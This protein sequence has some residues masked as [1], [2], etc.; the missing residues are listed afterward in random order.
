MSS[1]YENKFDVI[2]RKLQDEKD[3]LKKDFDSAYSK[4]DFRT[5]MGIMEDIQEVM[6]K[7]SALESVEKPFK[8]MSQIAAR[9]EDLKMEIEIHLE[10]LGKQIKSMDELQELVNGELD[11]PMQTLKELFSKEVDRNF[12]FEFS[13]F[14]NDELMTLIHYRKSNFPS[15]L[16]SYET[17][18]NKF[19]EI[20]SDRAEIAFEKPSAEVPTNIDLDAPLDVGIGLAL[21]SNCYLDTQDEVTNPSHSKVDAAAPSSGLEESVQTTRRDPIAMLSNEETTRILD[22]SVVHPSESNDSNWHSEIV[23]AQD[24]QEYENNI[25]FADEATT[26]NAV[27]SEIFFEEQDSSVSQGIEFETD[28]DNR[29]FNQPDAQLVDFEEDQALE[30]FQYVDEQEADFVETDQVQDYSEAEYADQ[31]DEQAE[32]SDEAYDQT[33]YM[34]EGY[35]ESGYSGE[36]HEQAEYSDEVYDQTEYMDQG[37]AESGYSGEDHEQAEYSEEAY[38]QTVY[39]EDGYEDSEYSSE[40]YEQAEYSDEAYN[41]T[42]YMEDGYEYSEYSGEGYEQAE[43]TEESDQV[44]DFNEEVH[45]ETAYASEDY[46]S[47]DY[48]YDLESQDTYSQ[49]Q[50]ELQFDGFESEVNQENDLQEAYAQADQ[51]IEDNQEIHADVQDDLDLEENLPLDDLSLELEIEEGHAS[52]HEILDIDEVSL[53]DSD[54]TEVLLDPV[55][56][57]AEDDVLDIDDIEIDLD[58]EPDLSVNLDD[59]ILDLDD[60]L[61]PNSNGD[62][63][64]EELNL[65]DIE[66]NLDED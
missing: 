59:E 6:N 31:G 25:S 11:V 23:T 65:D 56:A 64:E 2:F 26:S 22:T 28:H 18:W 63:L 33:E 8:Q 35:E 46:E 66:I 29:T 21:Q 36:G 3:Q 39:M 15:R 49:E 34:D 13:K 17:Y 48:D 7:L 4:D 27:G 44:V 60:S 5:S 58:E 50:E 62:E 24:I 32:N 41:Q 14:S 10:E 37:Y 55:S 54:T 51:S 53:E 20:H 19:R 40:D 16:A 43:Y 30:D 47:V 9:V 1:V 38:D 42:V 61:E 52:D 45:A 12:Q 57:N